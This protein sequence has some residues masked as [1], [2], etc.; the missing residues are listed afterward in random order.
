MSFFR[1]FSRDR[2][3]SDHAGYYFRMLFVGYFEDI[4]SQRGIV[5]R[6]SD[7]LSLRAFLRF[8]L[9]ETTPDHSSL[10]KIGDRLPSIG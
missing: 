1:L 6:C 8:A 10:S 7:S 3:L 4:A 5:W 2:G 9:N